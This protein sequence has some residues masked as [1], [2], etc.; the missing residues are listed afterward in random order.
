MKGTRI[1]VI[2]DLLIEPTNAQLV[3]F[4]DWCKANLAITPKTA[5]VTKTLTA[6]GYYAAAVFDEGHMVLRKLG[7]KFYM[8]ATFFR[9][10][11]AAVLKQKLLSYN[12]FQGTLHTFTD[13]VEFYTDA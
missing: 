5:A 11:A 10:Q 12:I 6:D 1:L 13:E 8:D 2:G 3:N 7:T 9:P 4:W